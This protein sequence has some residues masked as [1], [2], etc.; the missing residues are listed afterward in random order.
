[1]KAIKFHVLIC[2]TCLPLYLKAASFDCDKAS[3]AMEK[4]ICAN[5]ALNQLDS[6]L[7]QVYGELK[8]SLPSHKAEQ[9]IK[10]QQN[11][12]KDRNQTCAAYELDCL[13]DLYER[14]ITELSNSL[15]T[16][17]SKTIASTDK[18]SG[19]TDKLSV[20]SKVSLRSVGPIQFGMQVSKAQ[21]LSGVK[22]KRDEQ[23]SHCTI[24]TPLGQLENEINFIAV[25]DVIV[26]ANILTTQAH[27][28]ATKSNIG[29][30]STETQLI[31][32]YPN[33]LRVLESDQI[34][35]NNYKILAFVPKDH[36][37]QDYRILFTLFENENGTFNVDHFSAGQLPEVK[38]GCN[39]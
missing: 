6:E 26:S 22:F 31:K 14:R 23:S 34:E 24:L 27:H 10:Q 9:L 5:K 28:F 7:G 13:R 20:D 32:A 4:S 35:G 2:L 1:M 38:N 8:K 30:G 11:W 25:D 15:P 21:T 16:S 17:S 18:S 33:N 19:S 3:T 36:V 37:D 39:H 29:I 12:L